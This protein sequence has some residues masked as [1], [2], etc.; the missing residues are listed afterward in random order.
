[1][2]KHI[3]TLCA[4]INAWRRL[5]IDGVLSHV[6][7]DLI[8]N[9]SGGLNPPLIGKAAMRET[10]EEFASITKEGKWRLFAWAEVGDT[11]CIASANVIFSPEVSSEAIIKA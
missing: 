11:V 1:M 6:H 5:D 3:D 4:V 2:A 9:N 7:D 10:L 8:W